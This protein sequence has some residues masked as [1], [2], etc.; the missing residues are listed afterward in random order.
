MIFGFAD[1]NPDKTILPLH[2][3][4]ALKDG[5]IYQDFNN[6]PRVCQKIVIGVSFHYMIRIV[7][8]GFCN[9]V[10]KDSGN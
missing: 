1:K 8:V 7:H 3:N 10:S 5:A 2:I 6:H 4:P 9:T